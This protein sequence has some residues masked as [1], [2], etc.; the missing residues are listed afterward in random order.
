[1][2]FFCLY[3]VN[4][5]RVLSIAQGGN[6]VAGVV[7]QVRVT[8]EFCA[9]TVNTNVSAANVSRF[10]LNFRDSR[11]VHDHGSALY[12][13]EE[14]SRSVS[15]QYLCAVGLGFHCVLGF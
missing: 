1:M 13:G 6:R 3:G 7:R 12:R 2:S 4:R 14:A 10:V 9:S 11:G 8:N 15:Y 5:A